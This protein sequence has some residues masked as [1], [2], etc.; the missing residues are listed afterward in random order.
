MIE[1]GAKYVS[2]NPSLNF[3]VQVIACLKASNLVYYKDQ[4]GLYYQKSTEEFR[5]L[6]VKV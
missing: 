5:K 4:H 3:V 1:V 6:Y 2:A